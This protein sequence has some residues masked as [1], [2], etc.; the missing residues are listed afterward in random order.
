MSELLWP[1]RLTAAAAVTGALLLGANILLQAQEQKGQMM[2]QTAESRKLEKHAKAV[3]AKAGKKA[4]PAASDPPASGVPCI[5][6]IACVTTE[7]RPA[8][9]RAV[10]ATAAGKPVR[11]R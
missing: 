9:D 6:A 11:A 2:M 10:S 1:K 8:W 7:S 4:M 5:W 3:K